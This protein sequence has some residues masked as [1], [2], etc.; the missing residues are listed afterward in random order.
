MK[1]FFVGIDISKNS[2]DVCVFEKEN[3]SLFFEFKAINSE[4]GIAIL[5]K[6][7]VKQKVALEESW[8]CFEHTGTYGY[9]LAYCLDKNGYKYSA[10]PALEIKRSVGISRDKN[11]T[12]D[13]RKI[14]EYACTH[15]R[16][17]KQ[18]SF[19][20]ETLFKLKQLLTYRNQ[21][22]KIS[23][24]LK[25]SLSDYKVLKEPLCNQF[26]ID[27]IKEQLSINIK[28]TKSID[29]EIITVLKHD[30]SIYNNF[31]LATSVNGV[32]PIIAI[33]VIVYTANYSSFEDARKFNCYAGIAPFAKK[34]GSSIDVRPKVSHLANKKIKTLLYNGANS[35]VQY[36]DELKSYYNRKRIEGKN[37]Q[38][39]IN[40]V[41]CKLVARMFAVVK[42]QTPFV[43]LFSQ[44]FSK[45][46]LEMS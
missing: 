43:S 9:L 36:N 26:V 32:G 12:I 1:K 8:F 11:D 46:S 5:F 34:S 35:A 38:L 14:A 21:L 7:L 29:K 42:R 10:V 31:L 19:P 2:L 39:I 18:T 41:A 30:K 6:R 37:H 24:Q 45:N 40:A 25:N 16:K 20:S 33:Y 4:S 28:R 27:D 3:E 23:T 13:A 44:S 15:A 17:L 22:V